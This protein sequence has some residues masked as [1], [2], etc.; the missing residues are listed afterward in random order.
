MATFM[1]FYVAQISNLHSQLT[2]KFLQW[3]YTAK[4]RKSVTCLTLTSDNKFL[5]SGASDGEIYIWDAAEHKPLKSFHIHKSA[6]TNLVPISR[7]LNLYGLNA[8]LERIEKVEVPRF[9]KWVCVF[10]SRC[11]DK[12][13][14]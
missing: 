9:Q 13:T 2:S 14:E 8:N 6:V 11:H 1:D 4:Y 10:G 5:I 3:F 12:K 7:P